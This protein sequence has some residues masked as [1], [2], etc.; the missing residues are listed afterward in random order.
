VRTE[1][2]TLLA[3][4][5]WY[6]V[7]NCRSD[8]KSALTSAMFAN[9]WLV[10]GLLIG[11]LLQIAVVFWEP[12]GRVFHTV[13]FG[14]DVVIALALVGSLVLWVEELRKLVVRRR[15]SRALAK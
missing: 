14:F 11:N 10:G 8:T 15:L 7:L 1:T 13:P 3:I 4:C 9:R 6:N 12:L 5:E 2:F